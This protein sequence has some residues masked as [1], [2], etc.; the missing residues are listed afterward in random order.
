MK[1][2]E[3]IRLTTMWIDVMSKEFRVKS[4]YQCLARNYILLGMRKGAM[5]CALKGGRLIDVSEEMPPDW[6]P[7]RAS[8][9][10]LVL[11][12]EREG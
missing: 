6:C 4:C 3:S 7:L 9:I 12:I 2:G 1:C 11:D 5:L 8:D 10:T